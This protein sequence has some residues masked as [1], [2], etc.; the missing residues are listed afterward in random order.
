MNWKQE[1]VSLISEWR[2]NRMKKGLPLTYTIEDFI[3]EQDDTKR[4]EGMD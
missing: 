1:P 2:L 4:M 3:E